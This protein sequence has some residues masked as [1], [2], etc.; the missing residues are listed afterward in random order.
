MHKSEQKQRMISEFYI[1]YPCHVNCYFFFLKAFLMRRITN[2]KRLESGEVLT[3]FSEN[4]FLFSINNDDSSDLPHKI[5]FKYSVAINK[6]LIG[7]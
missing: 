2:L 6:D 7:F 1:L 5:T 4:L 3:Q